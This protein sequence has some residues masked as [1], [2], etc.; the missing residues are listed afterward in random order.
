MWYLHSG[1]FCSTNHI[2]LSSLL[3][4]AINFPFET[5]QRYTGRIHV[6]FPLDIEL[7]K[8]LFGEHWKEKFAGVYDY[9]NDPE[10]P[11]SEVGSEEGSEE[12]SEEGLEK[13]SKE[14]SGKGS[15]DSEKGSNGD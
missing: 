3:K 2:I 15:K 8:I 7:P 13:G 14:S 11:G 4:L 6:C 9:S 12:N 1:S 10:E 5:Q